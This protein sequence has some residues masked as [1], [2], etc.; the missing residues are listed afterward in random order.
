MKTS[1]GEHSG[2]LLWERLTPAGSPLPNPLPLCSLIPSGASLGPGSCAAHSHPWSDARSSTPSFPWLGLGC[3]TW[4]GSTTPLGLCFCCR[5][6]WGHPGTASLWSSSGPSADRYNFFS[7]TGA[8][9][10][11]LPWIYLTEFEGESLTRLG[12]VPPETL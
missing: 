10:D 4:P 9:P 3:R 11:I 5:G 6:V 7:P 8:E 1:L 2:G 12:S